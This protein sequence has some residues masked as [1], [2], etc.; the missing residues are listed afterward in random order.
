[1]P[2]GH[3]AY[4][5]GVPEAE[6]K[7]TNVVP[8]S[9]GE[10]VQVSAALAE[11]KAPVADVQSEVDAVDKPKTKAE[12]NPKKARASKEPKPEQPK[13]VGKAA[14]PAAVPTADVPPFYQ[15]HIQVGQIVKVGRHPE[16]FPFS[17]TFL[18]NSVFWDHS[19]SPLC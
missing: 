14:K 18:H 16:G 9:F 3:T 12:P 13:A 4:S 19:R 5:W 1:M 15:L 17:F 6:S 8:K 11:T 2:C 10:E 7:T